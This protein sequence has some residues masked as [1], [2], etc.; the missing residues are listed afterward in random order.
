MRR[1]YQ[2]LNSTTT[3]LCQQT[4]LLEALQEKVAQFLPPHMQSH[5]HVA[6]FSK[7]QLVL[8][9]ENPIL[10]TELRYLLPALRDRLRNEG[11]L[12]QLSAIKLN[13]Q[14]E[15]I[16]ALQPTKKPAIQH[17]LSIE[18]QQCLNQAA[19]LCDYA[20]L[21]DILQRIGR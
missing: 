7:G 9:L 8:S 21:R 3:V 11:R 5:C 12:H 4:L 13:I 20:P 2:C 14:A 10:A 16:V 6:Q 17:K 18:S 19:L 15:P 1:I